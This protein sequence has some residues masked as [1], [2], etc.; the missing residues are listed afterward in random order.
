SVTCKKECDAASGA[1]PASCPAVCDAF[2]KMPDA[3][4]YA[5]QLDAKYGREPDLDAMP[6]YCVPMSFKAVYDTKDMRSIGG[7]DAD[8]AMDAPP[9]DGTL[10]ARMRDAGAIIFA[11]ALNSEYNGGSG[12]PGGDAETAAPYIVNGGSRDTWGGT[13]CNPYNTER[14][15]GGSSG[16]SGVSVA[17]NLV[18]CSICETTGGSCR[19]PATHNNVVN[20]VPT[21][22]M[23]TY[24]GGIGADPFRDRPGVNCRTVKDAVTVLEAFRD[25]TTGF[26]DPRD[27]YTALS[28]MTASD[29]PYTEALKGIG[30][31]KPLAG[32][33]IGVIRELFIKHDASDAAVSDGINREL[34]ILKALGATLVEATTPEYPDDP[35]IENMAFSVRD[36][37]AEVLPFHMPEVFSWKL[38]DGTPEFK[39]PGWDVTSRKYLVSVANHKAPLPEN[40]DF[41]RLMG[42]APMDVSGY[43]FAFNMEQYL[44]QRGDAKVSDWATLNQNATYFSAD[45]QAAMTNW[46]NKGID[47]ATYDTTFTMKREFVIRMAMMK[48]MEQNDIDVFAN[49]TTTT[50]PNVIGGPSEPV[51]RRAFGYGARLGIPEVFVPAGF[52]SEIYDPVLALAD[53][54]K[55]Y[56]EK[57]GTQPTNLQG[58]P[59]PYNIGFWAMPGDLHDIIKVAAAYEAATHHRRTPPGF[60]PVKGEP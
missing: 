46:G 36:A 1:L 53:D 55:T 8:Y 30:G 14:V 37:I 35:A 50:L 54:G 28:H 25:P 42:N 43:S 48:V 10:A 20:L 27:P 17:A 11:K 33:R 15:T 13:V 56:D 4:E 29:T 45:K 9:V 22:G 19:S 21:K 2:R 44:Q 18:V 23:T 51:S 52:A 59:L 7:A 31:A 26:F 6:L 41:E 39:V 58:Y 40:L 49:P 3:V 24:G 5:A 12:N 34:Q 38:A 16:G 60:G 32:M 47:P 57:A